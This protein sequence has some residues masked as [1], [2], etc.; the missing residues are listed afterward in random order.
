MNS[1]R[2]T[3]LL[4]A[5]NEEDNI[6][7]CLKRLEWAAETIVIDSGSTDR[8]IEICRQF[9]GVTV[10]HNRFESF[11]AQTNF[12]L[13]KIRTDWVLSLDADYIMPLDFG[14]HLERFVL[15]DDV[16]GAYASFDYFVFGKA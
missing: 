11:A 12:G 9:P 2:V 13:S 14:Q 7:R 6:E 10:I 15:E 1:S 4:L 3:P 8:T 5:W 16:S